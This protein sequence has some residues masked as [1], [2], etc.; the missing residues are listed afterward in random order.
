MGGRRLENTARGAYQSG[1]PYTIT[2]YL[3][4]LFGKSYMEV[5]WWGALVSWR[6]RFEGLK[7]Y[8]GG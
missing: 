6:R 3:A 8:E 2:I 5:L 4:V 1:K 7:A